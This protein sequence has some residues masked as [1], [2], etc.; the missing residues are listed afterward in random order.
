MFDLKT[1]LEDWRR[2]ISAHLGDRPDVLDELE[3]H[4]REDVERRV[5]AGMPAE[6]A[7]E[8]AR[9]QLGEPQVLAAEFAKVRG[10]AWL[11]ARI[12]VTAMIGI[13]LSVAAWA[14]ASVSR[15]RIQTLL[16][17]HVMA[18]VVA[19]T[20][21]FAV[22]ALSVCAL[23]AR[24]A[25]RWDVTRARAFR[26]AVLTLAA[27]AGSLTALA[28]VLGALWARDHMGRYWGWDAREI[29]GLAVL[30]ASA[31]SALTAAH[32][33]RRS[34]RTDRADA[35][36][37]AGIAGNIV[38]SLSWFGPPLI[39]HEYGRA[40]AYGPYLLAFVAI[41]VVLLFVVLLTNAKHFVAKTDDL[42]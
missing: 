8:Q 35:V 25:N 19:Y 23:L 9:A 2:T 12:A 15:G 17:V 5:R 31:L 33:R 32:A 41:Q 21:V 6:Q 16:A 13:A 27:T 30:A 4:L 37:L 26:S 29:G 36:L 28:I 24:A 3:A 10:R 7:W 14:L 40:G 11:P 18:V 20:T 42:R 38:V 22:G 39:S 1:H 34:H